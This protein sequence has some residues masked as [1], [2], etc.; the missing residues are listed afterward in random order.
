MLE[1][2]FPILF[3][4]LSALAPDT[5][6]PATPI[7]PK[8]EAFLKLCET[9]RRG[10]ILQLEYTLRGLR[11]QGSQPDV[12]RRAMKIEEDLRALRANR[13]PVV[14]TLSFP[15]ETGAIGRLPRL[16]C[17]VDQILS[18]DEMLIRCY[19]PVKLAAVRNFRARAETIFQSVTFLLRGVATRE[20][21]EGADLELE[22]VFEIGGKYTYTTVD[23]RSVTVLILTEFDMQTV[24]SFFP[25]RHD[26]PSN[27]R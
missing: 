23:G 13:H 7:P 22:Q 16:S 25:G 26:P 24:E 14:P 6:S 21:H 9:N 3:S 1:I 12:V 15:P 18:D 19:F 10:A 4:S 2:L 11:R 5:T 27:E 17:H 8:I 20:V